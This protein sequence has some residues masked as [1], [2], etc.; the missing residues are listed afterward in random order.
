MKIQR[1]CDNIFQIIHYVINNGKKHNPFHVGLAELFHDDSKAKLVVEILNK[2]GLC[3]SYDELQ[4]IDFSLIKRVIN[5]TG[6]NRVPVSLPI[7]K[8][9]LLE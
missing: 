2:I 5:L 6:A 9:T 4:R 3:V 8:K 1:K 7:D